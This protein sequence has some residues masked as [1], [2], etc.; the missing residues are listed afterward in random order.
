MF[1]F[2][3]MVFIWVFLTGE[4]SSGNIVF[5]GLLSLLLLSMSSRRMRVSFFR[6]QPQRGVVN[7]LKHMLTLIRFTAFFVYQLGM[8]GLTV[9]RTILNPSRLRPGVIAVPLDVKGNS[10]ITLLANLITLTPGTLT[11]DV[12]TDKRVIYVHTIY[13]EDVE[14]F[15]QDIKGG[16]EKRVIEVLNP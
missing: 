8:A 15:R 9:F 4:L 5:A 14:T 10:E 16:F 7:Y 2:L 12:S 3:A 13:F 1:L 6:V 11:L